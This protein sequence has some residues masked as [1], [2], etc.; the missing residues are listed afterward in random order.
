MIESIL[1]IGASSAVEAL[2]RVMFT[3]STSDDIGAIEA[4]SE[5]IAELDKASIVPACD[6]SP[7]LPNGSQIRRSV[8][9]SQ[10]LTSNIIPVSPSSTS[11]STTT[12]ASS[13]M[14][15]EDGVINLCDSSHSGT[16]FLSSS[17]E[18]FIEVETAA[19]GAPD[20]IYSP[21]ALPGRLRI[22]TQ[23]QQQQQPQR[24]R[25]LGHTKRRRRVQKL[26]IEDIA[27]RQRRWE[28]LLDRERHKAA[29][30]EK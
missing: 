11:T 6:A 25:F 16:S 19:L 18:K 26:L 28:E 1:L 4:S 23:R 21:P 13:D 3:T 15:E 10:I 8:R 27:H 12:T 5:E 20:P 17:I 24:H 2:A 22:P 29:A 9:F 14:D 30:E 7:L